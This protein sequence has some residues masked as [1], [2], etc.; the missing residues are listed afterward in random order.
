MTP[1]WARTRTASGGSRATHDAAFLVAERKLGITER[2]R[3]RFERLGE[4]P[5]TS[6]PS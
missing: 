4:V 5:F 2:R 3:A 1:S 6:E